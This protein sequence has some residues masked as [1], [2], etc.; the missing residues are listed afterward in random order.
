MITHG[1]LFAGIGGFSTA[2]RQAGLHTIRANE[3]DR[4][5]AAVWTANHPDIAHQML[6]TS[7]ADLPADAAPPPD[8]LT[9]GFPCQP[10]SISGHR[11][12]TDD[13]R[14]QLFPQII[15]LLREWGDRRPAI[16]LLENVPGLL[17]IGGGSTFRQMGCELRAAGYHW[18]D[19]PFIRLP[20][21][22]RVL[23]ARA[24]TGIPCSRKRLWML[25]LRTD[26]F[27]PHQH[28]RWP[29]EGDLA[30]FTNTGGIDR[31]LIPDSVSDCDWIQPGTNR[32]RL[33]MAALRKAALVQ[34]RPQNPRPRPGDHCPTILQTFG[35]GGQHVPLT[36]DTAYS[37]PHN[38]GERRTDARGHCPTLRSQSRGAVPAVALSRNHGSKPLKVRDHAATQIS[39]HTHGRDNAVALNRCSL[40]DY[41]DGDHAITQTQNDRGKL[42]LIS[43]KAFG[44][45]QARDHAVTQTAGHDCAERNLTAGDWRVRRLTVEECARLMGFPDGW[46]WPVARTRRY[47]LLGNSVNVAMV[48]ILLDECRRLFETL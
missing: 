41:R 18:H 31:W 38:P 23:E 13:D 9:A 17:S 27:P 6:C 42:N 5:A 26:R 47:A 48:R 24:I 1:D 39:Q 28:F 35:T 36:L 44:K 4:H 12:G 7:I 11:R 29:A 40:R 32:H 43:F 3:I 15:R 16:C 22:W 37:D 8:I 30:T 21:S 34:T 46:V 20:Q 45:M 33:A 19:A 2:A 10:F 14:G 25:A